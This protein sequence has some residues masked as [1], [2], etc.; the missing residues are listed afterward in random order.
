MFF[1]NEIFSEDFILTYV[2]GPLKRRPNCLVY[3]QPAM[4]VR[5]YRKSRE[6][7]LGLTYLWR[8]R[9]DC[10][11][12]G[13][14]IR[15]S[16]LSITLVREVAQIVVICLLGL[17]VRLVHEVR[18]IISSLLGHRLGAASIL[19]KGISIIIRGKLSLFS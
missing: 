8:R 4:K 14:V 13:D 19:Y 9:C 12:H 5:D 2:G 10:L 11:D 7:H 16:L 6:N 17:R 3:F 1:S 15:L 18:H